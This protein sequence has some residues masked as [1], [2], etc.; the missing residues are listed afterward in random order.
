[1]DT[2]FYF[3]C[4]CGTN[5]KEPENKKI[6]VENQRKKTQEPDF[7]SKSAKHPYISIINCFFIV[8]SSYIILKSFTKK[9]V[10]VRKNRTITS[11]IFIIL[12]EKIRK[13]IEF[14]FIYIYE[15]LS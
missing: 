9:F 3:V 8:T 2:E 7:A 13:L 14:R 1:M 15:L 11:P 4:L 5:N 10:I 12:Y 6:L